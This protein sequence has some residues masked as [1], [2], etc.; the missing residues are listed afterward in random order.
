MGEK[1]NTGA[2]SAQV[3]WWQVSSVISED[4]NSKVVQITN[5]VLYP[6]DSIGLITLT[7]REV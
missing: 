7:L 4:E 2:I 1:E 5:G 6:I 3:D